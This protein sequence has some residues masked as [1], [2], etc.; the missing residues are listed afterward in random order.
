M[1]RMEAVLLSS[2][3]SSSTPGLV[4]FLWLLSSCS[5]LPQAARAE[6][7]D[8][9]PRFAPIHLGGYQLTRKSQGQ[10]TKVDCKTQLLKPMCLAGRLRQ[11][12][13]KMKGHVLRKR[14]DALESSLTAR[15][16]AT[17]QRLSNTT[18]LL[19]E[20]EARL[21]N[22]S[23]ALQTAL[24]SV[25]QLKDDI[26]LSA[27][28]QA[29][30]PSSDSLR[31]QGSQGAQQLQGGQRL[32]GAQQFKGGQ[33]FQWGPQIQGAQEQVVL[34]KIM[35]IL[36]R[37]VQHQQAMTNTSSSEMWPGGGVSNITQ[38]PRIAGSK[39]AKYTGQGRK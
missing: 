22:V 1:S 14:V 31:S 5:S 7:G 21:R 6:Q 8:G 39:S 35:G 10:K 2:C 36:L 9:S 16:R 13:A 32:Q 37:E 26:S 24:A 11:L 38:E 33:E 3:S 20:T 17:S 28:I 23:L 30:Q 29:S 4:V 27:Q 15:L 34:S 19:H 25:S 12:E 18:A